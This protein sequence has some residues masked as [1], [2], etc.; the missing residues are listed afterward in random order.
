MTRVRSGRRRAS[1][2]VIA[3]ALV[4]CNRAA[5]PRKQPPTPVRVAAVSRIDAPLTLVASGVVEPMQ[6]V[7]VTAQV[8]GTLMDVLFREG[9]YVEQG[10]V[11]FRLDPR[12]LAA[13]ADQARA[14]LARDDAQAAAARKDDGRYAKL[15]ELGFVSRSQADQFHA[16]AIAADATVEADRAALRGAEVNLGFTT[17]RAPISGRTGNLLVRRGNNVSPT[18]GPLVVINQISPVFVRFPVLSQ[19]L[20]N[21]QRAVASHPLTVDARL[22]RFN[23]IASSAVSSGF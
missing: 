12:Q 22:D 19:D 6:T 14:N 23:G 8:S 16:A 20:P 18:T 17:L 13:A 21:V 1:L 4:A 10:Q 7:S 11:L 2:I 5:P 3:V 15:A 9:D